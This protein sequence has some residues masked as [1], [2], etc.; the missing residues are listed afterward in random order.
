MSRRVDRETVRKEMGRRVLKDE[1]EA[2]RRREH[3][4]VWKTAVIVIV[5]RQR[6]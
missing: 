4:R 6:T 5:V 3:D 2:R 1:G